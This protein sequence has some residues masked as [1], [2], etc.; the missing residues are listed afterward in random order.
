MS[1]NFSSRLPKFSVK[2]TATHPRTEP[3]HA[4]STTAT[5]ASDS[6][7][8]AP[9]ATSAMIRRKSI[10]ASPPASLLGYAVIKN[11][12]TKLAFEAGPAYTFES[13]GG[14]DG[15]LRIPRRRRA[16]LPQVQRP[17]SPRPAIE[18]TAELADFGNFPPSHPSA[19]IRKSV[20]ASSGKSPQLHLRRPPAGREESDTAL[21]SSIAIRF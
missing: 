10:T 15:F 21:T 7:S 18:A 14:T 20:I 19:S 2:I 8:A 3:S 12:T 13:Q 11:D 5:S 6:T 17:R 4:S 9:S 1:R 16:I